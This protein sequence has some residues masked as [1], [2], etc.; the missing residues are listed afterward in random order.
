M[1]EQNSI[2]EILSLDHGDFSE[3]KYLNSQYFLFKLGSKSFYFFDSAK[4][5]VGFNKS[6]QT[7]SNLDYISNV[8]LNKQVGDNTFRIN[9][10]SVSYLSYDLLMQSRENSNSQQFF[11]RIM[12]KKPFLADIGFHIEEHCR[13]WVR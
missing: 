9:Y 4:F 7:K 10:S 8:R 11:M 5:T 2:K 1:D 13:D 6:A 3:N 12:Q